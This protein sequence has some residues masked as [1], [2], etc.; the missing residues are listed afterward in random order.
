[1]SDA[2]APGP[3]SALLLFDAAPELDGDKLFAALQA[4]HPALDRLGPLHYAHRPAADAATPIGCSAAVLPVPQANPEELSAAAAQCWRWPEG[5]ALAGAN[6]SGLLL[7]DGTG[8]GVDRKQR[9]AL[10]LDFVDCALAQCAPKV[11]LWRPAMRLV[12][13][14]AYR[15]ARAAKGDEAAQRLAID[16]LFNVR[17]FNVGDGPK[18]SF[19]MDTLGLAPLGLPDLLCT[20]DSG[21]PGDVA[22]KL[23]YYAHYLLE[24]GDVIRDGDTVDGAGGTKWSARHEE[25]LTEPDRLVLRVGP[26]LEDAPAPAPSAGSSPATRAED[27][28]SLFTPGRIVS[29]LG[30]FV[31]GFLLVR[32]YTEMDFLSTLAIWTGLVVGGGGIALFL[33]WKSS[34]TSKRK[35]SLSLRGD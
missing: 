25:A 35:S 10:F 9:L 16:V 33:F 23:Y 14:A 30:F 2:N 26:R 17:M 1:M 15:A 19:L 3:Y 32:R 34:R 24:R 12:D 8:L 28:D 4:R 22:A 13:P 18:G 27:S 6:R 21:E 5:K 7:V 31:G 20:A 11:I 29:F